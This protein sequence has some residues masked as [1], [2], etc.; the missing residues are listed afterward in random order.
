MANRIKKASRATRI[1][2]IATI[3][4]TSNVAGILDKMGMPLTGNCIGTPMI[5]TS[6]EN[7]TLLAKI[8]QANAFNRNAIARNARHF[9]SSTV[10]RVTAGIVIDL[11]GSIVFHPLRTV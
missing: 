9:G 10:P 11:A 2:I 1:V 5:I 8:S 7:T 4:L 3:K 6:V